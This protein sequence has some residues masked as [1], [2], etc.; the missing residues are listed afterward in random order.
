[1]NIEEKLRRCKRNYDPLS[2]RYDYSVFQSVNKRHTMSYKDAKWCLEN[3]KCWVTKEEA[4][5]HKAVASTELYEPGTTA[6]AEMRKEIIKEVPKVQGSIPEAISKEKVGELGL[7]ALVGA[8]IV[9]GW[10]LL[11]GGLRRT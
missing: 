8:I 4:K 3:N 1:M 6:S 7:V 2:H 10:L 11:M 5:E 9:A